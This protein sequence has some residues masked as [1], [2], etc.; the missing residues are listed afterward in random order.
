MWDKKALLLQ[1]FCI[2]ISVSVFCFDIKLR[3]SSTVTGYCDCVTWSRLNN[4]SRSPI[5]RFYCGSIIKSFNKQNKSWLIVKFYVSVTRVQCSVQ[6][7]ADE[8]FINHYLQHCTIQLYLCCSF[9]LQCC[10]ITC[11]SRPRYL[12]R[13]KE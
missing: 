3:N 6:T 10:S 13:M 8:H 1:R 4:E 7:S 2:L 11:F 5:V 12:H 9:Q